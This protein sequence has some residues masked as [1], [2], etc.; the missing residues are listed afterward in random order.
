[1]RGRLVLLL[2]LLCLA[3]CAQSSGTANDD[4]HNRFGGFYGGVSGGDMG[5]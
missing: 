5:P 1:M 3:G 4:N 2:M